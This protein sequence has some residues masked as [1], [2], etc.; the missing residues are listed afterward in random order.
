MLSRRTCL[1]IVLGASGALALALCFIPPVPLARDYH[2][3][4]DQ[5]PFFGIP[6]GLDVLSNIPFVLVG[7][8]GMAFTFRGRNNL[9]FLEKGERVPYFAFFAGAMLTGLGSAYYHAA[10]GSGRLAWDLLPMALSFMSLTDATIVERI[11][12]R[13]GLALLWPLLLLGAASV[14]YWNWKDSQGNGDLRFYLF[15][16]FFSPL[17][18]AMM[19]ALFPP[20][21]TRTMDLCVAF[22][23]F[24]LAKLFELGDKRIYSL[25]GVVSGH[26]L[27]H[28][29]A[30]FSCFWI[31]RM[32]RLRRAAR[33]LGGGTPA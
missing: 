3:F 15:V 7:L 1:A 10:P 33:G 21:Y 4:S 22:I 30:A 27:K 24:V 20:R 19:I 18:I 31:L 23:F 2:Y 9:S 29:A 28:L 11:S 13:M 6:R 25:G 32:L 12:T 5:R 26:T 8:W 16:Q 17:A 14:I